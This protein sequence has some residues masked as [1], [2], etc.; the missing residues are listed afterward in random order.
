[1]TRNVSLI[2]ALFLAATT[3]A[4]CAPSYPSASV[5]QGTADGQVW[6]SGAPVGS[7]VLVDGV[8]SGEANTFDG[9]GSILSVIPGR[10]TIEVVLGTTRL[11]SQTV[12]LGSGSRLEI[13]VR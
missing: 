13:K 10:H 3:A 4:G 2:A 9:R 7:R 6:I 11:A 1:M 8:D 5:S 12:M